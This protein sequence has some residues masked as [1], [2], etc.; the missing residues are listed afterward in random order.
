MLVC[1]HLTYDYLVIVKFVDTTVVISFHLGAM[2]RLISVDLVLHLVDLIDEV[3]VVCQELVHH[4]TLPVDLQHT[5][6]MLFLESLNLMPCCDSQ[7]E[8]C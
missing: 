3:F 2:D 6:S 8:N 4:A 1:G 7:S 5:E